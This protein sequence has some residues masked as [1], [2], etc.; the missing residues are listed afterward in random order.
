MTTRRPNLVIGGAFD[1]CTEN[2][3]SGISRPMLGPLVLDSLTRTRP[4]QWT[5]R[6]TSPKTRST[7]VRPV[8]DTYFDA[9]DRRA[10]SAAIC[11]ARTSPQRAGQPVLL[12]AAPRRQPKIAA[13]STT[14][15]SE[16]TT[17]CLAAS[18][19]ADE[20]RIGTRRNTTKK[21]VSTTT[22]SSITCMLTGVKRSGVTNTSRYPTSSGPSPKTKAG[23]TKN[24]HP[25][26]VGIP[27]NTRP[28]K[29]SPMSG[30][31]NNP[32]ADVLR[33]DCVVK[34]RF[35]LPAP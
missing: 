24:P 17:A 6:S 15:T 29:T 31:M 12:G 5:S 32:K 27:A 8:S 30:V 18:A 22:N 10:S 2:D 34:V 28:S 23:V 35:P 4:A 26:R 13:C 25:V 19:G 1:A 3:R 16:A 20:S 33:S 7:R 9:S 14:T 21:P 11:G